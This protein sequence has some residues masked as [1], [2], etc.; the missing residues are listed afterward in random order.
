MGG[1]VRLVLYCGGGAEVAERAARDAFA[2]VAAVDQAMSDYRPESEL[3]RLNAAAGHGD[4]SVS[5]PLFEVLSAA[6]RVAERSGGAFDVTVGPLVLLWRQARKDGRL[7]DA[8]ALAAARRCVGHALLVLDERRRTARL[9][10]EGM[11]LDLG[12]IAKGYAADQALRA[13]ARHGIRRA[14]VDAAGD[15]VVGEAPPGR[16]AWHIQIAGHPEMILCLAR[17]GVATSGDWERFA[18]IGGRRYSHIVDPQTGFGIEHIS[19]A[20]VVAAD[21]MMADAL[22]TAVSV[23][24]P[25]R[26]IAFAE[27]FPGVQ[28]WME[29]REK[30]GLR[31]ARSAG[32]EALLGRIPETP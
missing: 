10:R 18:E 14:L 12:A 11:K 9:E 19:L 25:S 23:L 16:D 3:S 15:I 32:L 20:T 5:E 22:A 24:G 21:G 13:L 28:A 26:G 2:A 1:T 29:W 6:R 8:G 17:C 7:P 30:G 27:S 31:S 4:Q